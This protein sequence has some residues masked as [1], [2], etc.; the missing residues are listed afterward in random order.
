MYWVRNPGNLIPVNYNLL[1]VVKLHVGTCIFKKRA[2]SWY[3]A[4]LSGI[5]CTLNF[6]LIRLLNYHADLD[7]RAFSGDVKLYKY[8]NNIIKLIIYYNIMLP[9]YM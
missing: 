2:H 6:I 7:Q 4:K 3:C 1:S 9:M 8:N 5:L